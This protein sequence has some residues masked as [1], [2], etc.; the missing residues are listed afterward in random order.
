MFSTTK[1]AHDAR[2][3][4]REIAQEDV[5]AAARARMRDERH[6]VLGIFGCL[7]ANRSSSDEGGCAERG[8]CKPQDLHR[9]VV[10][11]EDLPP[12]VSRAGQRRPSDVSIVDSLRS[13]S[14]L[15]GHSV[16]SQIAASV[17]RDGS[18][19]AFA[20]RFLDGFGFVAAAVVLL[21]AALAFSLRPPETGAGDRR[22]WRCRRAGR[23]RPSADRHG[24]RHA[25]QYPVGELALSDV[26]IT[27]DRYGEQLSGRVTNA[28]A[29]RLGTLTLT[30]TYKECVAGGACRVLGEES[31]RLFLALPPGQT[32]GFSAAADARLPLRAAPRVRGIASSP[33]HTAIFEPEVAEFSFDLAPCGPSHARRSVAVRLNFRETRT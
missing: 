11:S 14:S 7:G 31:P 32:N 24:P 6:R 9:H 4:L 10:S 1:H 22:H 19:A 30:V 3:M 27:Q 20:G 2:Q 17:Q 26:A 23:R 25:E 16:N 29:R 28:S 33:R 13:A 15:A 18:G 12:S 5:A 8:S 21:I